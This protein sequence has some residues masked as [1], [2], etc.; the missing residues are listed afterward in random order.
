M[1][2]EF[3]ENLDHALMIAKNSERY[4]NFT[5]FNKP[6]DDPAVPFNKLMAGENI[7]VVQVNSLQILGN[8]G[9]EVIIG[10]CGAFEWKNDTLRPLDGDSYNPATLVYGYEW[11]TTKDGGRGLEIL[12]G[13]DW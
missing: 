10:F 8:N 2:I 4:K 9:Y 7:D 1:A 6:G 13:E 11:F 5:Y 12:V 3:R